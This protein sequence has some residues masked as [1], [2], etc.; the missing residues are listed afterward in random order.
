MSKLLPDIDD[1]TRPFWDA[2]QQRRLVMQRCDDCG[3]YVW[4]PQ[5]WCRG[6]YG[7]AL[8]WQP[9][10]GAGEVFSYSVVHYAPLPGYAEDVPYV[11]ATVRLKEGPQMMTNVVGV[12]WRAVFIGQPV[13]VCWEARAGDFLVPQFTG[14]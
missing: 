6:C 9:L 3:A 8:S 10:S 1:L 5:R 4:H 11:L 13:K 2:A 14:I 7:Q 12:D